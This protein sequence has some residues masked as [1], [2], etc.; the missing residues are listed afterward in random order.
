MLSGL[1]S[2]SV[3]FQSVDQCWVR[4]DWSRVVIY[5]NGTAVW[6]LMRTISRLLGERYD[7]KTLPLYESY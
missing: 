6:M 5:V 4:S 3:S 7:T 1:V 2:M